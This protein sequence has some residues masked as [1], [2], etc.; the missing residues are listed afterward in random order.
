VVAGA[1]VTVPTAEAIEAP[2][3]PATAGFIW[4]IFTYSKAGVQFIKARGARWCNVRGSWYM[5]P[6]ISTPIQIEEV[7]QR[8]GRTTMPGRNRSPWELRGARRNFVTCTRPCLSCSPMFMATLISCIGP[9]E[10]AATHQQQA[11]AHP[12][13]ATQMGR[14]QQPRQTKWSQWQQQRQIL[15]VIDLRSRSHNP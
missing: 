12:G 2:P 6:T 11:A 7:L 8:Y 14:Q 10:A 5:H 3:L 9:A 4:I 1:E 15:I 13:K